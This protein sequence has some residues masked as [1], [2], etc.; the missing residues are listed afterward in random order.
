M[1]DN[2][3]IEN[4]EVVE[5]E[6]ENM[7]T[8]KVSKKSKREFTDEERK[9]SS[10]NMKKARETRMKNLQ[11]RKELGLAAKDPIPDKFLNKTKPRA[12]K[13][14]YEEMPE[15]QKVL[16]KGE[17]AEALRF[18]VA[19]KKFA[20]KKG[21]EER[22]KKMKDELKEM[23]LRETVRTELESAHN[24]KRMVKQ[25]EKDDKKEEEEEKKNIEPERKVSEPIDIPKPKPKQIMK[26]PDGTYVEF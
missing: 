2:V 25:W 23:K 26:F 10:E 11:I 12:K 21:D 13:V 4:N 19:K 17:D 20:P 18:E 16:T 7:V 9:K 15:E 22:L 6:K 1:T 3:E 8:L 14:T 5:E 24:R